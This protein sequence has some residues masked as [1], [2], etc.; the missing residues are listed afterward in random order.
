MLD[1]SRLVARAGKGAATGVDRVEFAYLEALLARPEPLFALIRSTLGVVLLGPDGT[2]ALRDR[3]GGARPWGA[4]DLL[5]R[6]SQR[7]NMPRAAAEADL[8]RLATGRARP[9][10]L[11]R[12]LRR[13]LPA[14]FAYLNTGHAHLSARVFDAVHAAGG[15]AAVLLHDTIP[16]DHPALSSPGMPEA[17]ARRL[18]AV[19]RGADLVICNS[20]ATRADAMR[21][22]ARLGRVPAIVVA[23]LGIDPPRPDRSALPP[24]LNLRPPYF[25]SLGTIE[26]RKNHALLLDV[27]QDFMRDPPAGGVPDLYVIGR[28]GWNNAALF[29][30]LEARPDHVHELGPLP[31]GAAAALLEGA[32]GLLFPSLA[33]GFGLPPVEAAAL[34][35]PVLCGDLAVYQETLGN[36]PVYADLSDRYLWRTKIEAMAAQAGP[37][38]GT[39]G[40]VARTYP[41]LLTWADHFKLV[42]SLT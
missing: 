15:R 4:P 12:L 11:A 9:S 31:D 26:P 24:G 42:L 36:Y 20:N 1:L 17:F 28:R 35:V 37:A 22:F 41:R 7:R 5:G 2:A 18:A 30:R 16:L 40:G 10:G 6:L 14:G 29:A 32:A 38:E 23:P 21:H 19:S 25:V 8:R 33:E 27:W 39:S 34:G 3:L 13:H